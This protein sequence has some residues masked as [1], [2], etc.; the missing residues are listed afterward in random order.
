MTLTVL[1]LSCLGTLL[2][3]LTWVIKVFADLLASIALVLNKWLSMEKALWRIK[4][5]RKKHKQKQNKNRQ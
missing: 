5:E 3:L 1:Y 2:M 4:K